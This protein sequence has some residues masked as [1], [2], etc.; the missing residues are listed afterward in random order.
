V[1][2]LSGVDAGFLS[3]ELPSQPMNTIA[4]G[5]LRPPADPSGAP[6]P[7]TLDDIRRHVVERLPD[8]PSFRWRMVRVPFGLHH[9]VAVDDPD[10]DLD[11][12]LREITIDAPGGP[13][14]VDTLFARLAER[15]LD[16]RHPLW[17]LT[18]VHGL[19]GRQALILKYHHCLADGVAALTNFSNIYAS[20]PPGTSAVR[21]SSTA[22]NT[23]TSG[24]EPLP[25]RLR[26]LVHA[27]LDHLRALG[28]LPH[29]A[30][31]TRRGLHK[32]KAR[33]ARTPVEVP[34][35]SGAAPN[36][37]L[38]DA[39]T[40]PRAYCRA[41]VSLAEVR[42]I[43]DVAGVT[44]N[45][46]VLAIVAGAVARYLDDHGGL[47]DRPLL[48]SVPVSYEAPDAPPRQ[49]GNRFWSFTTTLA[50]DV[51]DPWERLTVISEVAAEAKE[52]LMAL[53]PDLMPAWLD[54]VPPFV[55]ERGA[56]ALVERLKAST[57]LIDAN[58]L[59]SNIRG[60]DAP[61]TVCGATVEDLYI[62]GPP[63]NGVGCNV[64]LWSY[65]GRLLFGILAFADALA[66]PEQL[67]AGIGQAFDELRAAADHHIA[68]VSDAQQ[69][70]V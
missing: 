47:P 6:R 70:L 49:A 54:L 69:P 46:V 37:P 35:F 38:N 48:A 19:A 63:S 14:E 18:L 45:D 15:P 12:H 68:P 58:I 20:A 60:P 4:V 40:V 11:F 33:R 52:Q 16:R 66:D 21:T 57:D 53:G 7:L 42:R 34:G 39:F 1:H 8:L 29:L 24:P 22:E 64:M 56:K 9:P 23:T 2:R 3:M 13:A 36:G 50:T 43:K 31:R 25:G 65:A 10:F 27:L 28:H 59:V 17:Q 62:D 44:V 61:W 51:A 32:V 41:A 55:A 26:L 30:L 67:A 5:I